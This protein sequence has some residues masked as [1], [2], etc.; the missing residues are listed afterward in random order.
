MKVFSTLLL[1]SFAAPSLAS[2]STFMPT[3][4]LFLKDSLDGKDGITQEQFNSVVD[5]VEK[6]YK[7]LIKD[8]FGATLTVNRKW[9]DSTVNADASQPS[10]TNWQVNMYGGLARRAEVTVDGFAMVLCHELGHHIGGYPYVQSWAADEGQSDVYATGACAFEIF[11]KDSSLS[12]K[13]IAAIPDAQKAKCDEH[14]KD[15]A[16][17]DI[18]YRA[19]VAGKSLADL[20]AALGGTVANYDTPDTSTVTRTDHEHPAAQC[21]LDTYISSALCGNSKWDYT[22]IPGKKLSDRNSLEAQQEA[23]AHSCEGD[24]DT[25]R[26]RCWFAPIN[27]NTP[28][29]EACPYG[30]PMICEI[31]CQFDPSQP[32]CS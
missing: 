24:A 31:L 32:W 9:S 26:P 12:R 18:C 16:D 7:P 4:D 8:H 3:N 5:R 1:L 30:D 2:T 21:R 27:D 15:S 17:R 13:A 20:L 6:F 10:A 22:L 19:V 25:Q 23:F 14:H 11:A 28:E 29:P